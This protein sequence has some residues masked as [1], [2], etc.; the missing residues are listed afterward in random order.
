MP[1]FTGKYTKA[2]RPLWQSEDG[3][4]YSERTVTIPTKI[5]EDGKPLPGSKWVNVPSV[6]DGGKIIDDESFLIKFYSQNNYKDPITNQVIRKFD[7]VD[8]AVEYA[9]QRSA[10]ELLD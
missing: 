8:S 10:T 5:D 6:F 2:G 3:E 4:L 1:K 9:K 7:D